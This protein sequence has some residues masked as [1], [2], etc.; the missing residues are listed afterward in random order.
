MGQRV[1]DQ[2][3][4]G[5][6]GRIDVGPQHQRGAATVGEAQPVGDGRPAAI[7]V[8]DQPQRRHQVGGAGGGCRAGLGPGQLQQLLGQPAEPFQ[9][10]HHLLRPCPR[11]AVVGGRGEALG[12]GQGRGNRCAQ[13]VRAV[14]GE[15]ALALQRRAE[16]QQQPVDV[17]RD[18]RELFR[19]AV[20]RDRRQVRAPAPADL[21]LHRR[22]RPARGRD[23]A[24]DRQRRQRHQRGQ[25]GEEPGQA[26]CDRLPALG[27]GLRHLHRHRAVRRQRRV[28]A[29][30]SGVGEAGC[31]GGGERP[32]GR[33]GRA[34][35][36]SA[37]GV[38]HLVEQIVGAVLVV[39][40]VGFVPVGFV[41]VGFVP[42]CLV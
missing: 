1:V 16:P 28:E 7:V 17:G 33:V 19:Q 23:R 15:G 36:Q 13:L 37:G 32:G 9:R 31:D 25:R 6:G 34:D 35:Q 40:L 21:A 4:H 5:D 2:I 41:P 39:V 38:A 29:E 22:D 10:R 12:L 24:P 42:V 20:G 14:G 27:M 30:A 8:R 26:A 3:L 18:R 11:R